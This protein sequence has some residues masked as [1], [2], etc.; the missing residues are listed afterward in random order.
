MRRITCAFAKNID[1][2]PQPGLL[3]DRIVGIGST[4]SFLSWF[5][6]SGNFGGNGM[7]ISTMVMMMILIM[8]DTRTY[9]SCARHSAGQLAYI[10]LSNA[11]NTLLRWVLLSFPFSRRGNW[12]PRLRVTHSVCGPAGSKPGVYLASSRSCAVFCTALNLDAHPGL[13]RGERS[14]RDRRD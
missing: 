13:A 12:G 3:I 5:S 2:G 9:S 11:H 6:L 8:A 1:P 14:V 10:N 4:A 7:K